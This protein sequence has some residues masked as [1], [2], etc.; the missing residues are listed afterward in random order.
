MFFTLSGFSPKYMRQ[1]PERKREQRIVVRH[2]RLFVVDLDVTHCS[3]STCFLRTASLNFRMERVCTGQKVSTPVC[4]LAGVRKPRNGGVELPGV[5]TLR[6]Q[7]QGRLRGGHQIAFHE[8]RSLLVPLDDPHRLVQSESKTCA[9]S[10][11]FTPTF[12]THTPCLFV[13]C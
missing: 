2:T 3:C 7:K 12:R 6:Q 10:P 1:S 9:A 11:P 5:K 8:C 4:L 13:C